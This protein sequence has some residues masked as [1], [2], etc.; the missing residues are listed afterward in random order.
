MFFSGY[1]RAIYISMSEFS[2]GGERKSSRSGMFVPY[3]HCAENLL[4]ATDRQ[5]KLEV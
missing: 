4:Y 1:L 3:L 5:R 2:L